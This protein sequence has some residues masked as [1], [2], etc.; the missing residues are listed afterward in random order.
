M[1]YA[2]N[3]IVG[4]I[5]GIVSYSDGSNSSF[6]AELNYDGET[7]LNFVADATESRNTMTRLYDTTNENAVSQTDVNDLFRDGFTNLNTVT[8]TLFATLNWNPYASLTDDGKVIN[9]VV[10]HM[11]YT[12][13]FD[14]GTSYPVSATFEKVGSAYVRTNHTNATNTFSGA[15]NKAAIVTKIADSFKQIIDISSYS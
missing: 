13:A 15:P 5:S 12:I 1:S 11:N 8:S 7:T 2:V 9:S 3:S 4:N 6:N 14:D 10:F